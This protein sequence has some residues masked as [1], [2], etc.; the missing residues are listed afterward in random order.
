MLLAGLLERAGYLELGDDE[1]EEAA[2]RAEERY[3]ACAAEV[4]TEGNE[5]KRLAWSLLD[6]LPVMVGAGHLAPVARRWKT[7]INENGKSW[8]TWDELPE[9]THNT[10]AGLRQPDTLR[11]HLFA[12]VLASP[13]D[14][15]RNALRGELLGS[16]LGDAGTSH[17]RVA[18]QGRGRLAQ[19]FDALVLGDLVSVYLACLYG[20]DPTPVEVIAALKRRLAGA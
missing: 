1:V 12:V 2:A 17:V 14:H 5:A 10:V 8:A 16:F 7:Q 9:A 4:P 11:E 13:D 15:P 19:A 20:L 3:A 18:I 6:R